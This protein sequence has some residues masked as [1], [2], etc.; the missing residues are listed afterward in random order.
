MTDEK[1]KQLITALITEPTK[2]RACEVVG[3][4]PRTLYN[5]MQDDDFII[6]YNNAVDAVI[7]DSINELKLTI[8][9][10][11][12]ELNNIILN[13]TDMEIKLKAIKIAMSCLQYA[14]NYKYKKERDKEK[15]QADFWGSL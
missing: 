2:Q 14:N 10:S 1:R 9:N 15:K 7:D 6:E 8:R 5:Y 3:I 13:C 12:T 11:F 4:D